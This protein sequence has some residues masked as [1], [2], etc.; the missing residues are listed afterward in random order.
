MVNL[1]HSMCMLIMIVNDGKWECVNSIG[2]DHCIVYKKTLLTFKCQVIEMEFN[3]TI[4]NWTL[5]EQEYEIL[6]KIISYLVNNHQ[7]KAQ[8]QK[9]SY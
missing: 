8:K 5:W 7:T 1:I 2:E 9:D 4:P 6:F 3:L